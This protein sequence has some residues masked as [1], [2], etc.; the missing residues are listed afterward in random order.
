MS[1]KKVIAC[2]KR[3]TNF[4]ITTHTNLEGDALG[5]ELAFYRLVRSLGKRA[6]MVNDDCLPY[7]YDFMPGV[8]K[9]SRLDAR[10]KSLKFD[11]LVIL[12]CSDLKRCGQVSGIGLCGKAVLNIDHHVSNTRFG[13]INWVEEDS[14]SCSQMIYKLYKAMRVPLDKDTAT[15][16]YVGM[17]TDTG[18][19]HYH[20]TSAY[21]HYA[22]AELLGYGLD[23]QR[24]YKNI[25]Q[26]IPLTD[27]RLLLKILPGIKI[28]A[29]RKIA[30]FV[31]HAD[32]FK[33]R[34]I[35]LDLSE[36]LLNFARVI[37]GIEVAVLFKENLKSK[38]EVRVNFRS[39]GKVDVNKVAKL[40]GGGGHRTA[41][42]C[43]ISGKI[44]RVEER[45]LHALAQRL[46]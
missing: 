35:S 18:S 13:S 4:L 30:W 17:L 6:V 38:N 16:L 15:L 1:L 20:H 40:F 37:K 8:K 44:G 21:T 24:I 2:I 33:D 10:S 42:G 39:Q 41:S 34:K 5:S 19:F 11:C 14:S 25:Y 46:K 36:Q 3:K 28:S 43:T 26:S 9:I 32:V 7:G 22:V 29:S 27:I 45:V 31:L 23:I 12:D